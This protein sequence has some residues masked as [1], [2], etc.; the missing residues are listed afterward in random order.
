MAGKMVG[1]M[2]VRRVGRVGERKVRGQVGE[3]RGPEGGK[4][5]NESEGVLEVEPLP[6]SL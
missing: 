4:I 2:V 5:M 3:T 6:T 1:K